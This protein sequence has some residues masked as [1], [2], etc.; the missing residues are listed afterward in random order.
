MLIMVMLTIVI[1]IVFAYLYS[2]YYHIRTDLETNSVSDSLNVIYGAI[3][4]GILHLLHA[5]FPLLNDMFFGETFHYMFPDGTYY[6]EVKPTLMSYVCLDYLQ[7]GLPEELSKFL[8]LSLSFYLD[9]PKTRQQ[10]IF[11]GACVGIGFAMLENFTYITK[12][13]V[14]LEVRL[15]MPTMFHASLGVLMGFYLFNLKQKSFYK[16]LLLC[17][18][19]HGCYD[20]IC[21]INLERSMS[22][23]MCCFFLAVA[24]LA[25]EKVIKKI[26]D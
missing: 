3:A 21:S 12:L 15:L 22:L 26:K 4:I 8:A 9:P 2:K 19:L 17:L 6:T 7:V 23:M 1:L 18:F 10:S 20:F 16:G 13:G 5:F 11:R 24:V 14:P 25:G